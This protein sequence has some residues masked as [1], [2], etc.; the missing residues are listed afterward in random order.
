MSSFDSATVTCVKRSWNLRKVSAYKWM[1]AIAAD[2]DRL[3]GVF[4][5]LIR[6]SDVEAMCAAVQM[7]DDMDRRWENVA[8]AALGRVTGR[9]WW[10]ALNLMKMLLSTWNTVDGAMLLSGCDPRRMSIGPF[11]DA[12][13]VHMT[14]EMDES[15][16]RQFNMD[17]DKLPAGVKGRGVAAVARRSLAAFAAD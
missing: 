6:T 3:S 5:G 15:A 2:P 13:T 14:R 17:L 12:A 11:L 7:F 1:L 8:R 16:I 9:E 4:P 10:R